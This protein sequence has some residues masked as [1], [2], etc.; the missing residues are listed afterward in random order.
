MTLLGTERR[1]VRVVDEVLDQV[2]VT[3]ATLTEAR[4]SARRRPRLLE[5]VMIPACYRAIG[6]LLLTFGVPLE[7]GVQPWP[8]DGCAPCTGRAQGPVRPSCDWI[9]TLR[10]SVQ[11]GATERGMEVA[12]PSTTTSSLAADPRGSRSPPAS[13]RTRPG[14]SCSSRRARRRRVDRR[15]PAR[16]PDAVLGVAHRVGHQAT[17]VP[18]MTLNYP[19]GGRW[20]VGRRSTARS[21]SAVSPTT[22]TAGRRGQ[23]TSG[24]GR[25]CSGSCVGWKP[26]RLRRRVPRRGRAGPCR[27]VAAR[28]LL[29]VQESFLAA[30]SEH[31]I[32]WVDDANAPGASGIGAIPMNRRDGVRMSTALTYL[33]AREEQ[34][35]P[36]DM[37]R[38]GGDAG[39]GR[40]RPGE[41]E[42]STCAKENCSTYVVRGII[43]C[44]G[45]FQS[46]ALLLRSGIGPAGHLA[47][48]GVECAIEL[49]GVGENLM[50]HQGTAVFLI[51]QDEL[52][53]ADDR[54]CQLGARY[55]SSHGTATDDM[56]LSMW[57]AWDL[58]GFPD[59]R[60]A[61]GV[62][63]IER[64]DRGR[65]RP[66]LSRHRPPAQQPARRQ[67]AGRLPDAD[68]ADGPR[69]AGG[70]P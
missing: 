26:T 9:A 44:A 35:E 55:S 37:A 69:P 33:P 47:E 24:R 53:P 1:A 12:W 34:G 16:R 14:E 11:D 42:S 36:H 56:W 41:Q 8:P 63:A 57:S 17:F 61:L 45:A 67:A 5:L 30:V 22:T 25:T 29:P 38:H 68:G 54:V 64:G 58:G 27:A 6:M 15:R 43:L 51:P 3:P 28:R 2:W 65:A 50:D 52:E 18:G 21:P 59:L 10:C 23:A 13:P 40:P 46:P 31:G 60:A 39:R 48:I 7:D 62:P 66:T 49:P 32:G 20:V 19:R 4:V 70:G